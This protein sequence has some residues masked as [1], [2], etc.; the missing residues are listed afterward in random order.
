VHKDIEHTRMMNAYED[1]LDKVNNLL[2]NHADQHGMKY[3]VFALRQLA[4]ELAGRHLLTIPAVVKKDQQE[5]AT[6]EFLDGIRNR[7]D[8]LYETA[9]E[10][11]IITR[12]H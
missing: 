12:T 6:A 8:E 4:I 9:V 2:K 7:L 3:G 11:G 10:L 1:L 5:Q